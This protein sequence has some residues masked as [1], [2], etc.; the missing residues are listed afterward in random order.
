MKNED[1]YDVL[2]LFS[3]GADSRLLLELSKYTNMKPYCVVINYEQLHSQEIENSINVLEKE[4]IDYQIVELKGLNIK[5]ALTSNEKGLYNNV[6]I[7]NVPSRNL[8][9][10]SIALSIAESKKIQLIWHGADYSDRLNSFP[11]CFQE[12]FVQLNKFIKYN[13]SPDI[14]VEA[15]LLGLT[16]EYILKM[17]K[18]FGIDE[19]ELFSG[20]GDLE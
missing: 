11:D 9:F 17:L 19:K 5:S 20:Y 12:F 16:K 2:I 8:M 4:N 1:N 6:S 18:S 10:L 15:P 7:W 14:I 13:T 3:S